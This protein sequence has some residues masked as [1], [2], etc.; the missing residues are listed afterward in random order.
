MTGAD[1][2]QGGRVGENFY[3]SSSGD[4]RLVGFR[5]YLCFSYCLTGH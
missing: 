5:N 2:T 4:L 1:L 3:P